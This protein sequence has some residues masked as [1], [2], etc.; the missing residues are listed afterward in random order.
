MNIFLV[1]RGEDD[2][3]SRSF[4][5]NCLSNLNALD[6][7]VLKLV[8]TQIKCNVMMMYLHSSVQFKS[9]IISI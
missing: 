2:S 1:E 3:N 5:R 7:E 8:P 4:F 9:R 6:L